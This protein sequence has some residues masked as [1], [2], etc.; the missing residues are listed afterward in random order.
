MEK[1]WR[2]NNGKIF[3]DS[4]MD[5]VRNLILCVILCNTQAI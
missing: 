2:K 3:R 5:C 1:N 4:A